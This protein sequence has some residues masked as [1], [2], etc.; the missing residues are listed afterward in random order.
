MNVFHKKKNLEA[1]RTLLKDVEKDLL[2]FVRNL[3]ILFYTSQTLWF[4]HR[5]FIQ[6]CP[7]ITQKYLSR[8]LLYFV[9]MVVSLNI[10]QDCQILDVLLSNKPDIWQKLISSQ[11]LVLIESFIPSNNTALPI[12]KAWQNW[13]NRR[14]SLFIITSALRFPTCQRIFF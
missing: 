6:P 7:I 5:S 9:Y 12:L 8:C 2:N 3:M 11:T 14:G 10:Q 13:R 1:F 4:L